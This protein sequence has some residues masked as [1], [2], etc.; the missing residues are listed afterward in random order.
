MIAGAVPIGSALNSTAGRH[1]AG[2]RPNTTMASRAVTAGW[3]SNFKTTSY[4]IVG[5]SRE[6]TRSCARNSPHAVSRLAMSAG[7]QC[8][9]V[10]K[11]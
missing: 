6:T 4:A 1:H 9:Q 3:T 10:G 11:R 2:G 8:Q 7:W 5:V